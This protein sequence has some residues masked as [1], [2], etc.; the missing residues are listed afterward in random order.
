MNIVFLLLGLGLGLISTAIVYVL[1]H[2][3]NKELKQNAEDVIPLKAMQQSMQARI[4]DLQKEIA[5][6][7][8]TIES[9]NNEIKG[10]LSVIAQ[11]KAINATLEE[12]LEQQKTDIENLHEKLNK[13]FL[14]LANDILE[15]K[16]KKFS[17]LN[18]E[19]IGNILNPLKEKIQ[20]FEKKVEDT[21]SNETREKASLREELKNIININKQMSEDAQKL[22]LALKGDSKTQGDWGEMQLERLLEKSGLQKGV[23]FIAQQSFRTENGNILRPD[24]L[25][26]LPEGK[27]FIIDSKVSLVAYEKHFN[28]ED[29]DEKN[30]FL[31]QHINSIHQH[32]Q[33]LSSKNYPSLYGINSPDFVFLFFALEPALTLALQND[34]D[35]FDKALAKNIVLVSTS[36]LLASMRTVSFIWKQENQ[37]KN[38]LDIAKESG[39]LYDKFVLFTE[40]LIKIGERIKAT[41]ADYDAAMN[42]LTTSTKKGDTIIGRM[43]NIK[44]LGANT[45]KSLDQRLIDKT[46][47]NDELLLDSNNRLEE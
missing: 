28:S 20:N 18:E 15:E 26:K 7:K 45:S 33:D 41:K 9:N 23:H 46:V 29:N 4:D 8:T 11:Y 25:I 16:T 1:L 30:T 12:K 34:P 21:Y 2:K 42:K 31:K 17:E 27:N 47:K 32:I 35:L 44:K 37:K 19:K 40:D 14:L 10:N 43:E 3:Q 24:Y 38:V 36:T 5:D 22:T 39:M 13:E 6:Y